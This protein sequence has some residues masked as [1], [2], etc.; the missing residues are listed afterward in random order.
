[1]LAA[2]YREVPREYSGL[3]GPVSPGDPDLKARIV[4]KPPCVYWDSSA[5]HTTRHAHS[6][7]PKEDNG[8]GSVLG[9]QIL[10]PHAICFICCNFKHMSYLSC[11]AYVF[12]KILYIYIILFIFY[13]KS[14]LS[15]TTRTT[16]TYRI[17]T[18]SYNVLVPAWTWDM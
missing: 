7:L 4:E 18:V 16:R 9:K 12:F 17:N 13:I 2:F 14:F 6:G 1:L 5:Q 11:L 15:R 3:R 10:V 8:I